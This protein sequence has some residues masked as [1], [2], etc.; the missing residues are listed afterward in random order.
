MIEPA[1]RKTENFH[2]LLWLIKDLCWVSG[3]KMMGMFM[4]VP[5]IGLAFYITYLNSP[6]I[7][8]ELAIIQQHTARLCANSDFSD[9][10]K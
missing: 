8:I 7:Q 6:I 9:L 4:I 1:T 3:T 10:F 5:T 2:I